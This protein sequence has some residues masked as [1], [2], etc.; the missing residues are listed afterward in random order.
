MPLLFYFGIAI[1]ALPEDHLYTRLRRLRCIQGSSRTAV[2]VFGCSQAPSSAALRL[3][4]TFLRSVLIL[5]PLCSESTASHRSS[6]FIA[7]R[8]TAGENMSQAQRRSV[9][10]FP[11]LRRVRHLRCHSALSLL[12]CLHCVPAL[13]LRSHRGLCAA[14]Y[15]LSLHDRRNGVARKWRRL[16][17]QWPSMSYSYELE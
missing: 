11:A 12:C 4:G 7:R 1:D 15:A 2:M 9:Y 14:G 6:T 17:I 3:A 8:F 16:A 10:V 13:P 5:P